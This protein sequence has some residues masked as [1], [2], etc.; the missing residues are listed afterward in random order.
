MLSVSHDSLRCETKDKLLVHCIIS[1]L[2]F[3]PVWCEMNRT[4]DRLCLSS[5]TGWSQ[6]SPGGD[7]VNYPHQPVLGRTSSY[8]SRQEFRRSVPE[9][10]ARFFVT[11]T[12]RLEPRGLQHVARRRPAV[13]LTAVAASLTRRGPLQEAHVG[14]SQSVRANG[15]DT[16]AAAASQTC[17]RRVHPRFIYSAVLASG[18][19]RPV[20]T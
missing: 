9:N 19:R 16:T 5:A 10:F 6:H 18:D 20:S 8:E 7:S 12:Y 13:G 2:Y 4:D 15:T 1:S 17:Q 11:L 3:L 14:A